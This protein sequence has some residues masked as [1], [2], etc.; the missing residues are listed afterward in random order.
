[1]SY[2]MMA[3][4]VIPTVNMKEGRFADTWALLNTLPR[5]KMTKLSVVD[6]EAPISNSLHSYAYYI[7]GIPDVLFSKGY[8]EEEPLPSMPEG[9]TCLTISVPESGIVGLHGHHDRFLGMLGVFFSGM[10][11]LYGVTLHELDLSVETMNWSE[12]C[13][14]LGGVHLFSSRLVK[15]IG[16]EKL[17]ASAP[18]HGKLDDGGVWQRFSDDYFFGM[19]NEHAPAMRAL[20]AEMWSK[21]D[22]ESLTRQG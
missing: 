3:V 11:A 22:L 1:M 10:G 2:R 16:Q 9:Y 21:A 18:M 19:P 6:R 8:G 15:I 20:L 17:V 4:L 13:M 7:D 14:L 5:T 12:F